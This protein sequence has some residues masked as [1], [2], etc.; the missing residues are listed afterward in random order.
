MTPAGTVDSPWLWHISRAS[1]VVGLVVLT[2]VFAMGAVLA[3]DRRLPT[4]AAGWVAGLHR[5]L[6][7]GAIVLVTAH[8]S[9]A[10]VDTYVDL[11]W[12]SVIV[13]FTSG[14]EG[15][16][17]GIGTVALDLLVL[18][19]ATSWLR[20][21]LSHRVWHVVHRAAYVLAAAVAV[22]ALAMARTDQ[23]ALLAVGIVCAITLSLAAVWR[24]RGYRR[25]RRSHATTTAWREWR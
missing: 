22:H 14:Y 19:A 17:V 24:L 3:T 10:A 18:V 20:P 12:W 2:S 9:T 21:R 25:D 7:L 23:P 13:P 8:V 5:Y 11:G 16:R 4:A 6:S 15:V 1:G